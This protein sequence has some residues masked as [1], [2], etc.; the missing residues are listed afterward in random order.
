MGIRENII[1]MFFGRCDI[2]ESGKGVDER[3]VTREYKRLK[4]SDV[5]CRL[6]FGQSENYSGARSAGGQAHKNDTSLSVRVFLPP[7]IDVAAGSFITVRQNNITYNL[8]C[9]SEGACYRHHREIMA[10]PDYSEV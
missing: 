3:G 2:Y 8:R 5:E 7:E 6:V 1:S 10:L 4:Y 9:T